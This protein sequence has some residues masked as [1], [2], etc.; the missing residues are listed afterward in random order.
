[1]AP[2]SKGWNKDRSKNEKYRPITLTSMT[3]KVLEQIVHRNII[4]H[5]DQQTMLTDV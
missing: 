3:C 1:M 5:L 4:S 2:I